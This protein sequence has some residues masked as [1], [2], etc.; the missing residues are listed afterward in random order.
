MACD[1]S[2]LIMAHMNGTNG[3]TTFTDSSTY[4]RTLTPTSGA[5][6][7]TA[8]SKFGG[9]SGLFNGST[10]DVRAASATDLAFGT[11]DF[12]AEGWWRF[13]NVPG[14]TQYLWAQDSAASYLAVNTTGL[15]FAWAGTGYT[16]RTWAPSTLTWYHIA[17]SKSSS[18]VKLFVDGT[19]VGT[20]ITSV[21]GSSAQDR[22]V[23]GAFPAGGWTDGYIDEFRLSNVARYSGNFTPQTSEFC[24]ATVNSN[25]MAFMG[26]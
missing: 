6:I 4:A 8:Q 18:T 7:S 11:G 19:Q 12:T 25:F 20:D 24:A 3:S 5:A 2:T 23:I 17:C 1:S 22:F 14:T 10:D 15:L 13:T 21:T 16:A 26:A 9:A